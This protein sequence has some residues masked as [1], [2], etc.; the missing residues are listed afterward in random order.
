MKKV[1]RSFCVLVLI[2]SSVKLVA[3]SKGEPVYVSGNEGYKS[4]RIPAIIKAPNGDLLAFCEG[5]VN[6]AG[7]FGNIKIVLKKSSDNGKTWSALQIVASNDTLQAGNPA[8]VLDLTDPRFPRGR[9]FLFYNTGNGHEG[10]LRKGNGHRDVLYKTSGDNGE[11]WSEPTDITLQVN[12]IY[13]PEIN[14]K[15]NFKQDWRSYANT[16][17]HAM[18]FDKGKYEGRIY[19]AAN[20]SSGDPKPELRDYKAHGYYTDDHGV[21]FHLSETVPFEGSNESTA[22]QLTNN[23]LMMNSRN[24]TG[25]YRIVSLSNDGGETWDTTFVDHNL[26]DPICEGS[27]LNIGTKKGKSVLAFSNNDAVKDRDS[28]TLRISFNEGK[29]WKKK[30]LIEP[31]NTGYSDIIKISKKEIGILYEADGYKEIKFAIV[32]WK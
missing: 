20:H 23:S 1:I 3:Q 29:A 32:K 16:P 30:F 18:Q 14:P 2:V 31:K 19:I 11:T 27:L 15:W 24:Q 10:E 5:R 12:R 26:P 17:G 7:D 22:A 25:K 8:P 4:F 13:Q 28:L 21:T 6:G 9:I